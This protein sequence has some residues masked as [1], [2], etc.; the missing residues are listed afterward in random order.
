[1]LGMDLRTEPMVITVPRMEPN[2]YFSIQLIDA[3]T[4]NFNYI[5]SRTTG[6]G[7]GSYLIAGHDWKG[8]L[9][10]GIEKIIPCETYL[11]L[12]VVRT[13]LFNPADLKNVAD[14]QKN[15]KAQPLSEFLGSPQ[16][17]AA[18]G[19]NFIQPLSGEKIKNSLAFFNVLNF[20][21]QYCP[22]HPSEKELRQKF[23]RI[24]IIPGA[25]FDST[26]LN[27]EILQ[28][29]KEGMADAW[30][31]FAGLKQKTNNKEVT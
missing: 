21:L 19:I 6:N 16:P 13:Q 4:H 27:P 22:E 2:R 15:Y 20:L 12:A 28:A 26:Q 1:M 8:E 29:I 10:K 23:A 24:G 14:I 30:T 17:Q 25:A 3:Y 9:P 5:G 11:A 18:A 7:G 31:E